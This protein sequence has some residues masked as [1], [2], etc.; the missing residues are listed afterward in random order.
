MKYF[1]AM[2]VGVLSLALAVP[3]A[4]NAVKVTK[5]SADPKTVTEDPAFKALIA[6]S[7]RTFVGKLDGTDAY[8]AVTASSAGDITAYVCDGKALAAWAVGT[9]SVQALSATGKSGLKIVATISG[10]R[11]TGNVVLPSGAKSTFRATLA[12]YPAGLW[13]PYNIAGKFADLKVGWI[14]LPDGTQR[15]LAI[16]N[17]AG[18]QVVAQVNTVGGTVGQDLGG[19]SAG[20]STGPVTTLS[21]T[22]TLIQTAW[23]HA[24]DTRDRAASGSALEAKGTAGMVTATTIWYQSGC[25]GSP[26]NPTT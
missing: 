26:S 9:Q 10:S 22:C 15:G 6:N 18:L 8:I 1:A 24:R 21:T 7:P 17:K 19:G 2:L 4:G 13:R 3:T 14:V 25:P 20:T 5:P 23:T 16:D 11:A 12:S